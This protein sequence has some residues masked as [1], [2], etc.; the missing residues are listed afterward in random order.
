MKYNIVTTLNNDY[1]PFGILFINSLFDNID[2]D[3]IN[4]I[5]VFDTGL[6]D[7]DRNFLQLFPQVEIMETPHNTKKVQMHD[8]QWQK[9]VYSKTS[10]LLQVIKKDNLPTI[11][12]DSDCVFV[13]NFFDL[14]DP[15]KD[16]LLCERSR[17]NFSK[18]IGSFFVAHNV[19]MAEEF[20]NHWIKEIESGTGKH[21]ESPALARI[22]NSYNNIG[23]LPEHKV[24]FFSPTG[25]A[26][27]HETR[28]IHLKSDVGRETIE[29]RIN[30]PLIK[31]Y[32]RRY[33]K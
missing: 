19:E 3:Y 27:T 2:L 30:Q 6:N 29:K 9:N 21:K 22:A 11:M 1:M 4:K 18:Y 8:K 26:P 24:S 33:L 7:T 31:G 25:K 14:L 13:S 5:Y 16:F 12:M 17:A 32:V 15:S 20:I 23:T 10:F 28:I